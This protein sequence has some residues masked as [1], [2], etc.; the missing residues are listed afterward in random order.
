M[1]PSFQSPVPRPLLLL[2]LLS[3]G[4]SASCLLLAAPVLLGAPGADP[5]QQQTTRW[6][7][8]ERTTERLGDALDPSAPAVAADGVYDRLDGDVALAL[9]AG[10]ELSEQN[11]G[12]LV[13]AA[14][15]YFYTAG[16][17]LTYSRA[18]EDA[19]P[20]HSIVAGV[21]VRPLFLP[22]W[23]QD[24]ERG[25]ALLDLTVDS[26]SLGVGAFKRWDER[27][28]ST[29]S[30]SGLEVSL[31][32]GVPLTASAAGPWLE[33]RG[34]RRAVLG[35]SNRDNSWAGT[36]TLSWHGFVTTPLVSGG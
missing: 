7:P 3:A 36:F 11:A 24:W 35:R 6:D 15:H 16:V 31:G 22:R 29:P 13:R 19:A 9:G 18:L 23:S 21:D 5:S 25:P 32:F 2:R 12:A 4:A 1:M 26:L 33:L 20:R 10:A 28:L 17:T 14:A 8:G 30:D 34:L 27:F